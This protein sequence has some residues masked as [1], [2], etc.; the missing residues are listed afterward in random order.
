MEVLPVNDPPVVTP[1]S[2]ELDEDCEITFEIE[3]ED[4]TFGPIIM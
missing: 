2:L 1:F 3:V 4:D